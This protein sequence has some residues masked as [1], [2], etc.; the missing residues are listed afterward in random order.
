[1]VAVATGPIWEAWLEF[2]NVAEKRLVLRQF[3]DEEILSNP[4]AAMYNGDL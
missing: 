4:C 3:F 2:R 1:M